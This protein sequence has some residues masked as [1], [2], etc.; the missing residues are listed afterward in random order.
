MKIE[1]NCTTNNLKSIGKYK[2]ETSAIKNLKWG[3]D[4][5]SKIEK[6]DD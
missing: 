4:N 1:T 6:Y 3:K 5:K 2:Y